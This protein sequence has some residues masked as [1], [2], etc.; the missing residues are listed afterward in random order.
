[1]PGLTVRERDVLL[2]LARGATY[3]DIAE[4]LVVS[5]NTVKTHVANLYAKLGAERRSSALAIA[6]TCGLL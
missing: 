4:S 2:E 5:Q 1:V 6:R 3:A